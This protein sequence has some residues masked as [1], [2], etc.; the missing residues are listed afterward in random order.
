MR[1]ALA[2][3]ALGGGLAGCARPTASPHPS[4]SA[5]A[6][7]TSTATHASLAPPSAPS[8]SAAGIVHLMLIVLENREAGSVLGNAGA[9]YFNSLAQHY[10]LAAASYARTHPS[11]PNYVDLIS[12]GTHGITSDCTECAVDGTTVADQLSGAGVSWKAYMEG[13]PS[14]CYQGASAGGLYVKKHDPFLYFRHLVAT[15]S[16]CDRVVP[17]GEL[18]KDLASMDPPDFMWVT[19]DLCNDGHDC[20]NSAMDR[21]L[22]RMVPMV[23]RS[24]WFESNGVIIIT[25]DEGSSDAGCCGVAQGGQIATV[26]ITRRVRGGRRWTHPVD[27]AGVLAT[28]EDLYGLTHIGEAADGRSGNLLYLTGPP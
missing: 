25:F 17:Y 7:P 9:P 20:P 18:S 21:W 22:S 28:V 15:P 10:G 8:T 14:A 5:E 27:T 19:P 16:L 11:L 23:M 1:A 12:G 13:M 4:P 2:A 26:V 24:A 3:V 6:A